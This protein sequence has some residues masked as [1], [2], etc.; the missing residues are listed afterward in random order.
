[1]AEHTDAEMLE[2]VRDAIHG[3]L[4]KA[5]RYTIDGRSL[6]R[7]SLPELL[8]L[9]KYYQRKVNSSGGMSRNYSVFK[10]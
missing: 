7:H 6:D 9:E 3:N 1:M 4:T 2:A 5:K 10:G 8:A